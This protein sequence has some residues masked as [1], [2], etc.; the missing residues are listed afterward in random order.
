ME[1]THAIVSQGRSTPPATKPTHSSTQVT[2]MSSLHPQN[3]AP[4]QTG[5]PKKST[6]AKVADKM[7][8]ATK[9]QAIILDSIESHTIS[10]S[11]LALGEVAQTIEIA[12][13]SKIY[14]KRVCDFMNSQDLAANLVS[15][16]TKINARVARGGAE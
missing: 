13:I 6:Y 9:E 8:Y 12:A 14:N 16:R 3:E 15:R 10:D 5:M 11:L 4:L 2:N 7:N 1:S